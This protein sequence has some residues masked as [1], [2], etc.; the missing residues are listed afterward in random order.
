M[1]WI[2]RRAFA[3]VNFSI[4]CRGLLRLGRLMQARLEELVGQG[5]LYPFPTR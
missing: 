3:G 2:L 5:C 4:L 1:R